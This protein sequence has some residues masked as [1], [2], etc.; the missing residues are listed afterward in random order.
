[1]LG[2]SLNHGHIKH[3]QSTPRS[4]WEEQQ[5]CRTSQFHLDF[6]QS[7][8]TSLSTFTKYPQPL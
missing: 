5:E 6:S 1:M 3:P 8:F 2:E 4:Q 7:S